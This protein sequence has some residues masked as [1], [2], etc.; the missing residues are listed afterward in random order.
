MARVIAEI[1][2]SQVHVRE[3]RQIDVKPNYLV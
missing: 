1:E 2:R 3:H